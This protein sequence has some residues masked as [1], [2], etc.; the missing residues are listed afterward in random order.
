MRK[1]FLILVA[2]MLLPMSVMASSGN[3]HLEDAN[4]DVHDHASLQNGARYYMNYCMGCHGLKAARY[5]RMATDMGLPVVPEK[6]GL[7]GKEADQVADANAKLITE[8][9]IFTTDE[10]GKPTGLGSLMLSSIPEKDAA[11]WFGAP[12]PDLSLVARLRRPDWVYT[13]LKSFYLDPERPTGVNNTTFPNVGMPH[14]LW[15]L[16]GWQE[17]EVHDNHGHKT[18]KLKL[19]QPGSMSAAEYDIVVR[20]ITN[21]LTYTSEPAQLH[22]KKY[23]IFAMILLMVF[24]GFAYLLKKE[25]WKDI[26]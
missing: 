18:E 12:P 21:F 24:I 19:A 23:G 1:Q 5:N 17:L 15:E 14:V 11:K 7:S 2:S 8:N 4:I 9:L 3:I 16:Q 20:D 26:H 13:Y 22:R 25:F 6:T 10:A